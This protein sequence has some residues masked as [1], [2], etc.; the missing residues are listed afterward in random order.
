MPDDSPIAAPEPGPAPPPTASRRTPS[1]SVDPG[2]FV[3]LYEADDDPWAYRSSA[4]EAAK[5]GHTLQALPRERYGAALEIGCSVGVLTAALAE[6][7]DALLG[8]DVAPAALEHAR[9]WCERL[10]HVE[11]AQA[12][13]PGETP[14]GPFDLVVMSEVGYYLSPADLDTLRRQIAEA[15]ATGGHLI[16]VHWTGETDYPLTADDVHGAFERDPT[17]RVTDD[18]PRESYRLTVL[19]RV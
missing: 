3:D 10:P 15:L 19:E 5:Y 17:W 4:Y 11:I 14:E 6:R 16:L 1:G 12:G 8:I 18:A 13:V 9:E 2:Y 7:C